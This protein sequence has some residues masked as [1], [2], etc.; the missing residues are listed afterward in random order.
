M[1][2]VYISPQTDIQAIETGILCASG[3]YIDPSGAG[4]STGGNTDGGAI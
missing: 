2:K 3:G 1:K 4:G